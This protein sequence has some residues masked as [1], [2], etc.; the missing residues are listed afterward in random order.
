VAEP[1]PGATEALSGDLIIYSGRREPLFEPVVEA[2]E[3][4][5]GIDVS[6]KYG[7][8]AELGNALIE[9]KGNA[10]ADIFVGTDAATAE[11]LRD[12]GVFAPFDASE[13]ASLPAGFR[14]VDGSWI[15]VSGRA[16]VIMYNTELVDPAD[17][18]SSVFDLI[19]AK[20]DGK[21]AIPSTANSSFTAWVSSL[22]KLRGDEATRDLLEGL[23]DNDVTVL[24]EHTDVRNAVGSG[25]FAIGLVNHYY[26]ELEKE[27][28]SPV[29]VVYPD[30]G[31]GQV[32]VLLN[33]AAASIVG[34]APHEK[35][36]Q[37]FMRF[38]LGAEAQ[39]IFAETNFE[40][41]L[42]P[43]VAETR[44]EV[45]RGSFVESAI[46]LAELGQMNDD[47]LDFLDEIALE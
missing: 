26:Y 39:R 44:A 1:E 24:R 36:A 37:A 41:P 35:N 40:Y 10:R 18:P 23:K 43:G 16:R 46:S 7:A 21:I 5:T 20:W 8:T 19:D 31:P 47:T 30:H 42:V 9:E 11:S 32:G 27:E 22:R 15:G 38:L 25:E 34:G 28:G 45:E 4:A 17:V 12:E 13:L 29:A 3:E 6:V 14:A 2:F 33:V